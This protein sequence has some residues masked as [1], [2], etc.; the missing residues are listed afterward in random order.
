MTDNPKNVEHSRWQ[1][2]NGKIDIKEM[3]IDL[4]VGAMIGPLIAQRRPGRREMGANLIALADVA[5]DSI[6]GM[7]GCR[8]RWGPRTTRRSMA[9]A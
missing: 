2:A 6:L 3:M 9:V 1:D 5:D 8:I 7:L 4:K